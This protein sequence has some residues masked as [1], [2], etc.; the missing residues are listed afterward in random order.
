MSATLLGQTYDYKT[1]LTLIQICFGVGL[2]ILGGGNSGKSKSASG[3]QQ[4]IDTIKFYYGLIAIFFANLATASRSVLYKIHFDTLNT[5]SFYMNINFV[6][7]CLCMPFYLLKLV[8]FTTTSSTAYSFNLLDP[9][10]P[11]LKFLIL[12]S[13]LN[14]AYNLLS[15]KILEQVSTLTHS[16]INIMKRMYVVF[17]SMVVLATKLTHVQYVGVFVADFG[18][19]IYAYLKTRNNNREE[20]SCKIA[21]PICSASFSKCIKKFV[22][23]MLVLVSVFCFMHESTDDRNISPSPS[24]FEYEIVKNVNEENRAICLAKIKHEIVQSFRDLLP[25]TNNQTK[26][27]AFLFAVPEHTN[28][29]DTIIW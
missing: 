6:S 28:Y 23:S 13:T 20:A 8:F 14:F 9:S 10:S 29:G 7:F 27:N 2:T 11:A 25:Q 12:A 3:Q 4:E 17:G 22:L 26:T 18:C 24:L 15:F 21:K 5:H 1:I 19:L 16:I